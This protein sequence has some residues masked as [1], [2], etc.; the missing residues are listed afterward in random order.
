MSCLIFKKACHDT[1]VSESHYRDTSIPV[2]GIDRKY[3]IFPFVLHS[4]LGYQH[5]NMLK[6]SVTKVQGKTSCTNV[7]ATRWGKL[8]G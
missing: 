2:S 8:W 6:S 5:V 4:I 3:D 7:H 1:T